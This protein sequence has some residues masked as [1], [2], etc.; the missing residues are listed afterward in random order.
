M[1]YG[2]N[3]KITSSIMIVKNSKFHLR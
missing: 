2:M 1:S 3:N